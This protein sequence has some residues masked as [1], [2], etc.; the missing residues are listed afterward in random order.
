LALSL[1]IEASRSAGE[2]VLSIDFLLLKVHQ[3]AQFRLR[4]EAIGVDTR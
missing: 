4:L 3:R 2:K 1:G